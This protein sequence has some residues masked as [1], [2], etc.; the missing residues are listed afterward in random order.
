M[1][2]CSLRS[3]RLICEFI[4]FEICI[5]ILRKKRNT[6]ILVIVKGV[7]LFKI[8]YT[9]FS[10]HTRIY[11][12]SRD[13]HI[14]LQS[15]P[16]LAFSLWLSNLKTK[17]SFGFI[18]KKSVIVSFFQKTKKWACKTR[19]GVLVI[20]ANCWLLSDNSNTLT[21]LRLTSMKLVCTH[22]FEELFKKSFVCIT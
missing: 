21:S 4:S 19:K 16:A 8:Q 5:L 10:Y 6:R 17:I 12:L 11:F 2:K 1:E 22:R 18:I 20:L 15:S 9:F 3:K 13:R 14:E 7:T